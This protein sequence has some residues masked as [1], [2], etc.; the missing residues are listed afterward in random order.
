MSTT[1][2]QANKL[3]G[4]WQLDPRRSSVEFRARH[5]WGLLP[6]KGH[7]DYYHGRLDLGAT[8]AIELTIDAATIQTGNRKR[9][10]HL[11][12][13]DFFDVENHPRVQFVSDSVEL[14]RD[15]LRVAG[16]LSA[17][18]R[19]IPIELDAQIRRVNGELHI[20][21]ATTAPHR[22]LGM[23][24]SPLRMIRPHSRLVVNAFLT[25]GTGGAT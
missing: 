4:R 20:Q 5:F 19:S 23:T 2:Q 17:R 11:R 6:V 24:W 18:G 8:R 9:D 25:P 16:R 21:A 7:F 1:E 10:Q 12:S 3:Q 14:R 22:E 15:T 13:A